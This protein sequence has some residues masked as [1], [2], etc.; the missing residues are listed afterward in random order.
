MAKVQISV[1]DELLK[2]IDNYSDRNYLS[3]SGLITLACSQYLNQAEV[4][5][6]VK[7]MALC[8]RKIADAGTVDSETQKQLEDFERLAQLLTA[9]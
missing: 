8:M 4:V 9:K 1:D 7:D 5:M 2:R 6:V 3:R